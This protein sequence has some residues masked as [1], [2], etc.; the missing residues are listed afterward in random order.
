MTSATTEDPRVTRNRA[1]VHSAAL[2]VLAAEGVAGLAVERIAEAS[3]V[4]RSTI[5]RHWPD[6][7][8]LILSAFHDVAHGAADG[9]EPSGDVAR[10]LLE[11][12]RDYARRLND[13]TYAAVIIAIVEWSWRDPDFAAEHGRTFD[14]ARSRAAGILRAGLR[15]GELRPDLDVRGGVEDVVAP[16]LYRRL[17][18]R[19]TITDQEVD[20]L[21]RR[22]LDS[23]RR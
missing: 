23:L 5:Y 18:L 2:E 20:A 21:H 7:R 11:Y 12:L 10:D 4:S 13:P 1:A 14:D 8:V 15:S 17:V 3:G 22:L 9:L 19:R 16:F 6:M